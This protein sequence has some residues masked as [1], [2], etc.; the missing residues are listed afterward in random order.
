M[1]S[2]P[3]S[4]PR[5]EAKDNQSCCRGSRQYDYAC[6]RFD[7]ADMPV[8]L[9]I[10][11]LT[12]SEGPTIPHSH[13]VAFTV[14]L[15]DKHKANLAIRPPMPSER[16][17]AKQQDGKLRN[18]TTSLTGWATLCGITLQPVRGLGFRCAD[19]SKLGRNSLQLIR[20]SDP[21]VEV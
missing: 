4:V 3:F 5:N 16:R 19:W 21:K 14:A 7:G 2:T 1:G 12:A 13:V 6:D 8:L 18:A 9:F 11:D 10:Q 15:K 20:L 17:E